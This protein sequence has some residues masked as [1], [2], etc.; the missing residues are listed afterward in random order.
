MGLLSQVQKE[1]F[2]R[3]GVLVVED[4]VSENQLEQ[5]RSVFAGWVEDSR[6][7]TA[8]YGQTLDGRARFDL[9]PGHSAERPALRRV[10]SP[11]EVS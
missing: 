10:Q 11:E 7:H 4:A 8:D 5:L 3:D 1:A 6:S 9:Q 2:W